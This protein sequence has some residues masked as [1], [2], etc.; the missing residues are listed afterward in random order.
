MKPLVLKC[1]LPYFYR[2]G[3]SFPPFSFLPFLFPSQGHK[4]LKRMDNSKIRDSGFVRCGKLRSEEGRERGR[5]CPYHKVC[6]KANVPLCHARQLSKLE[7]SHLHSP[8]VQGMLHRPV[9]STMRQP[10]PSRI[11]LRHHP[12]LQLNCWFNSGNIASTADLQHHL[13][14]TWLQSNRS[15]TRCS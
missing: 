6:I 13:L 2:T 11:Y 12:G 3:S 9:S 8:A 4:C 10:F 1:E 7:R 14:K 5:E 15:A